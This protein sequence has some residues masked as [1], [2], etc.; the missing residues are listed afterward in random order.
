MVFYLHLISRIA[1]Q[2]W[3]YCLARTLP[4]GT[5][6]PSTPIFAKGNGTPPIHS[7]VVRSVLAYT[8]YGAYTDPIYIHVN[9]MYI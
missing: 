9:V 8:E 6:S 3:C 4:R 2:A 1:V 7:H 5:S